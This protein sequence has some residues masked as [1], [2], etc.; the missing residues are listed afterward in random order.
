[1]IYFECLIT[2]DGEKRTFLDE[3]EIKKRY[4]RKNTIVTYEE[5]EEESEEFLRELDYRE[6]VRGLN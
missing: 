6:R 3:T 5:Y 2:E 1:M 4:T